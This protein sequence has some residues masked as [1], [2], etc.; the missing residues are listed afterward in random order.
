M[1]FAIFMRLCTLL[2]LG[3]TLL[4]S[5]QSLAAHSEEGVVQL[6]DAPV[7]N[8][9]LSVRSY[10]GSLRVGHNRLVIAVTDSTTNLPVTDRQIV[11]HL[12][13]LD[14]QNTEIIAQATVGNE[15]NPYLYNADLQIEDQGAYQVSVLVDNQ[16]GLNGASSFEIDVLSVT[17][18]K[19]I[20]TI[21]LLQ[22]I[23][24]AVWLLK[25]GIRTWGWGQRSFMKNKS[26]W[27]RLKRQK[28]AVRR[29]L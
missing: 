2:L 7:G 1:K 20:V 9:R 5:N 8:Y 26:D 21:L 12:T 25:E 23:I 6:T 4:L 18:F 24:A 19:W 28:T 17:G 11:I 15:S 14:E 10:P 13:S 22:A 3:A 27:E 16:S 29:P